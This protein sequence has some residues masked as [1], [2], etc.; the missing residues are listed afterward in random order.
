VI[1]GLSDI[2]TEEVSEEAALVAAEIYG[3]LVGA[4]TERRAAPGGDVLSQVLAGDDGEDG[5]SDEEAV[6]LGFLFLLAGLD[7]VT[8]ALGFAFERLAKTPERRR[9]IVAN[10][11]VIPDAVE[12]LLRLDPPAPF[13]PRVTTAPVEIAGESLAADERIIL[14]LGALNHDPDEHPDPDTVDFHRADN[15]H[16]SFGIGA[17]R[18]LGSHL[19]R[20]EMKIIFE[21]WHRRIPDY[22][23][24]P[25]ATPGVKW[26]R[27]TIGLDRLPLVFPPAAAE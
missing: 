27:G 8:D 16:V 3:Y 25:G 22:S 11:A 2:S 23:I 24:A 9:E 5:L 20:L 10:P 13:V 7:T 15:H 19:A 21:E 14:V 1:L 6:G 12:E 4:I 17:H 26:P 18:C